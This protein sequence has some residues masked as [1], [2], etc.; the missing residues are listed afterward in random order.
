M[1]T[2]HVLIATLFVLS[3]WTVAIY[4]D[5]TISNKVDLGKYNLI[6]VGTSVFRSPFYLGTDSLIAN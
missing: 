1:E 3:V 5:A 4:A 2:R 6:P